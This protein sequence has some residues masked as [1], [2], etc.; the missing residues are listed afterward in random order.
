MFAHISDVRSL[1]QNIE[2]RV[3]PT[4][5]RKYLIFEVQP[6]LSP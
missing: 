6:P 1:D 4:Y 5:V 3:V 2:R